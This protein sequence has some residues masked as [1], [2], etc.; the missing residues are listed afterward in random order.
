MKAY[1]QA[2]TFASVLARTYLL[3]VHRVAV[4]IQRNPPD[5]RAGTPGSRDGSACAPRRVGC[6]VWTGWFV[7][8]ESSPQ[9]KSS[10]AP[11]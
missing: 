5:G 4:P 8:G 3:P 7:S 2:A 6:M 10:R 1:V 11:V 9:V